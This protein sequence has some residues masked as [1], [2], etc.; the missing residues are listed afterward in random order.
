MSSLDEDIGD[1]LALTNMA[2]Q[3]FGLS[4]LTE[5]PDSKPG[6]SADCLFYRAFDGLGCTGVG[7]NG[8]IMFN[9]QR[10]ASYIARLWG[11]EADGQSVSAPEQ[12]GRV[13]SKF[14]HSGLKHYETT[15]RRSF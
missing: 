1:T 5:L 7:A 14:D 2:R 13:I 10:K 15:K 4:M 8:N 9:D 3:A 6:D 11:V 12:F